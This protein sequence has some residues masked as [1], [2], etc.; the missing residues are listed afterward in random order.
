MKFS[1]WPRNDRSP[2]DLLTDV[3]AAEAAG[4]YGAWLADHY[5]PNTG[6]TTPARG[7]VY[8]CWSLLPAMATVTSRIRI[9]TLVSP[10][11][12][13]HP[14]LLAKRAAAIDQLSGGRM[15]L[16]LGAGW[17]INEHYA[18]G[19]ELEPPGKRVTRFDEAIQIVRALLSQDSVSFSG[20]CYTITDAPCDPKPVQS[21]LPLLVGTRSP[22][23]LRIT[24]RHA[25]EWNTWGAPEVAAEGRA[26]L[27]RACEETGRDPGTIKTSANAMVEL[28]EQAPPAGRGIG[29]SAQ[30][31]ADTFGRYAELGFDEFIMPDWNLGDDPSQR[32]DNVARIKAEAI[33]Q[34]ER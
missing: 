20:A 33:D 10:T 27:L 24:A 9:G 31:L 15:V 22:R 19:I 8:E 28:G 21:P 25:D 1:I 7:D 3:R 6:D 26:A 18:Y 4:W 23:M 13:H 30:Q 17:Q 2:S 34:L 12:V 5:M 11:S 14:A 29:G 32:A 16:G